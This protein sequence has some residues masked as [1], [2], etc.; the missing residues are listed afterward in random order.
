MSLHIVMAG[1]FCQNYEE[2]WRPHQVQQDTRE[3][4]VDSHSAVMR[5]TSGLQEL[6]CRQGM[7]AIGS[8][9]KD[10]RTR[11]VASLTQTLNRVPA[12]IAHESCLTRN[13][14]GK[15]DNHSKM[16]HTQ[17]QQRPSPQPL[18]MADLTSYPP[19]PGWLR[20]GF[21]PLSYRGEQRQ[22]TYPV[23]VDKAC[24]R[25]KAGTE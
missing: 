10:R 15:A 22:W 9:W 4:Q 14:N 24:R 17:H 2:L 7:S 19:T 21:D 6:E 1:I 23:K 20:T 18:V 16:D 11:Q 8:Q 13:Q 25:M 3:V 12:K 5:R